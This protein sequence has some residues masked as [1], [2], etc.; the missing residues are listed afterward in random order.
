[1]S[2]NITRPTGEQLR[3]VSAATGE[4]ILDDYLE[5]CEK[6]GRQLSDMLEDL[7][8]ASTGEFDGD[9]IQL[10]Y[11][12]PTSTL[13]YRVGQFADPAAGW[14]D[15]TPLLRPQGVFSGATTYDNFDI[16]SVSNDDVYIVH[17]LSAAQTFAD[18]SAFTSSS[19]TTRIVNLAA[20]RAEVVNAQTEVQNARDWATKTDGPVADSEFSAKQYAL[21]AAASATAAAAPTEDVMDDFMDTPAVRWHI[22]R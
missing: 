18:E 8:D 10:R 7:F 1:M 15:L 11:N 3:F 4:H 17:G 12:D 19:N 9:L 5:A 20:V 16:V 6:G 13:Q 22:A 21:N 14:A 2:A